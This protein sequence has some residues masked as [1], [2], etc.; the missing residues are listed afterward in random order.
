[1]SEHPEA[2]TCR[3]SS[4]LTK[5][6]GRMLSSMTRLTSRTE[7]LDTTAASDAVN[8]SFAL[9]ISLV[10]KYSDRSEHI[11]RRVRIQVV[12]YRRF[13]RTAEDRH[14]LAS[15]I[16]VSCDVAVTSRRLVEAEPAQR[17]RGRCPTRS[18]TCR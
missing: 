6:A 10:I 15:E 17:P 4:T 7:T 5:S 11:F 12:V 13:G 18:E 9:V 2:R 3:P 8:N 1:M 14:G 16:R